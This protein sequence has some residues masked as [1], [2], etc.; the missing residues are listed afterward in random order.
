MKY[1]ILVPDGVADVPLEELGGKTPLEAAHTPNMDR[2]AKGAELGTTCH[3]PDGMTPGSAV[4]NMSIL[5]YDPKEFYTGR[6]PLEAASMGLD[7]K[8]GVAFRCNLVTVQDN[9]IV[10]FTAG[11]I[12][13]PEAA[14]IIKSLDDQLGSES[15]KFH[16]GRSYRHIMTAGAEW[17][18]CTNT[19]P[20]DIVGQD[21]SK[22]LPGGEA[23]EWAIDLMEK[24]KA[25]LK[26]HSVNVQRREKGKN[27]ATQI[28]L[29]G[30][31]ISPSLPLFK[32]RFGLQ[33][34][35]I[36]AVDL[37][38]GIA[39]LIGFKVIQVPGVTGFIDTNYIG[40][41]QAALDALKEVD[42]VYV[43]VEATDETGHMG[44]AKLKVQAIEDFDRHVVGTIL[45]GLQC[46]YKI[47]ML[48]DHPTPVP[49]KTHTTDPVPFLIYDSRW[50]KP[51][52]TVRFTE[53]AAE[54]R[55]FWMR[56]GDM[57]IERFLQMGVLKT[58]DNSQR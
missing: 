7:L 34:A 24:S 57:L 55:G 18:K 47:M 3:I 35:M 41:A 14:E 45:D 29:W 11:H 53:S 17:D 56:E 54:Q 30:Q 5:G 26:D 58:R 13:T 43:H 52:G 51:R 9:K 37:L 46:D 2:L 33:G 1:L 16:P 36:T 42:L 15:V 12:S 21:I 50:S 20:H 22:Y 6:G 25:V 49:L 48:P 27:W 8:G 19:P 23:G 28:W 44:D 10:D 32:D 38:E 4:A 31:G 40:K 39:K